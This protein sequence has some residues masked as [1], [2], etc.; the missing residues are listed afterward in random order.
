[1]T[2]QL[3]PSALGERT[4]ETGRAE[5]RSDARRQI[6]RVVWPEGEPGVADHLAYGIDVRTDDWRADGPGL[7]EDRP[8]GLVA[9]GKYEDVGRRQEIELRRF[10][11][12]GQVD[13]VRAPGLG[14]QAIVPGGR[15][16]GHDQQAIGRLDALEGAKQNVQT[17]V[18]RLP[19]DVAEQRRVGGS[20]ELGA[21]ARARRRVRPR[22]VDRVRA[23]T[24]SAP[25]KSACA[26]RVS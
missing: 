14:E 17:L 6:V 26:T 20:P 23:M 1:V 2:G 25:R 12:G 4:S 22:G 18:G 13:D 10:G 9:G 3:A 11:E 19:S 5:E 24:R 8:E 7:E 16:T 21:D 15:G